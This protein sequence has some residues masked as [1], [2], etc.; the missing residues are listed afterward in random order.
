MTRP[1]DIAM[2]EDNPH[3]V[4]LMQELLK[5]ADI[6][7]SLRVLQD[8][9]EGIAYIEQLSSLKIAYPDLL[10]VDLNLPKRSG[11]EVLGAIK[12]CDLFKETQ[13][14]VLTTSDSPKDREL[15]LSNGATSYLTKPPEMQN[16]LTLLTV[17]ENAWHNIVSLSEN[18]WFDISSDSGGG[19]I[20]L[21]IVHKI[22]LIEDNPSDILLMEET[23]KSLQGAY[24][25]VSAQSLK[26]ALSALANSSIDLILT[27]LGLPDASGTQVLKGLRNV[28]KN[29]PIVVLSGLDD[30]KMAVDSLSHGAQDYLVKGKIDGESIVRSIR[31][32]RTRK[33]AERLA[34][35]VV[36]EESALLQKILE[37]APLSIA[38]FDCSLAVTACNEVFQRQVS[39][40]A[41]LLGMSIK[42]LLPGVPA[43]LWDKTIKLDE[44][45]RLEA[46]RIE[47]A[48][49][50]H[51]PV[52]DIAVWSTKGRNA[53]TTG[54]IILGSDVTQ[55]VLFESQREDFIAAL[56]H[57]I[58][59][60]LIGTK[61]LLQ[62]VIGGAGGK[63]DEQHEAILIMLNES[64][65][66]V[67]TLLQNLL[68][69]Y[70]YKSSAISLVFEAID[71]I[72]CANTAIATIAPIAASE[73]IK[74]S[75]NFEPSLAFA[76]GDSTAI[77]R[78]LTN[79]L[80]NAIKFSKPSDVIEINAQNQD[81]D[82]VVT[83]T[84]HGLGMTAE[85]QQFLFKR[86]GQTRNT[87]YKVGA[88]T[89]LGLY[90]CKQIVDAHHGSIS[91]KSQPD[92]ATT[93]E[94][95]LP[96]SQPILT[97]S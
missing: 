76:F 5:D 65:D 71:L 21:P 66:N 81:S 29:I 68:D 32:A 56:A 42:E 77:T 30:E 34:H 38:R 46:L 62:A 54:G 70:R 18:T 31:Y 33:E 91:C 50:L 45:F 82:I 22:L 19:A 44:P 43:E 97:A 37:R 28:A 87:Q 25:I 8:G 94:I 24:E 86:F 69:V 48:G 92:I 40:N 78:L 47:P 20:T 35:Q 95:R 41:N 2:I 27:D 55:R 64:N 79:L 51:S 3:D 58:R 61:R 73:N 93:F 9:E 23:L 49:T 84:D 10:F 59:N 6:G 85:E 88:G 11:H 12:K 89:G 15:A 72:E 60:P 75:C 67:L 57:D 1:I 90:L 74:I 17:V 13:V 53:G 96:R 4:L 26:E 16:L 63:F 80:N 52:W 7:Y 14:V 39:P 36:I 83:V